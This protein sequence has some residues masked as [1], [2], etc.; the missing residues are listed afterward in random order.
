MA[1]QQPQVVTGP[2]TPR[3]QREAEA[4]EVATQSGKADRELPAGKVQFTAVA[5]KYRLQLISGEKKRG[6]DF[7]EIPK[8]LQFDNFCSPV[9]DEV[10]DKDLIE[11]VR[12]S[13]A[14]KGERSPKEIFDF[15]AQQEE[16]R[17]AAI[18]DVKSRINTDPQYKAAV[19]AA[20]AASGDDDFAA[21]SVAK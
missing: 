14:F 1:A 2:R 21:P 16:R 15:A 6:K 11:Q 7:I 5:A 4:R 19:L 12:E 9:L 18:E 20:L 10:K 17:Q 8:A 3:E 13:E